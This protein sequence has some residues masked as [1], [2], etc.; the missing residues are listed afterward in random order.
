MRVLVPVVPGAAEGEPVDVGGRVA[1]GPPVHVIDL[2]ERAGDLAAAYGAG[3]VQGFQ[4]LPLRR[5]GEPL[6][7]AEVE[8]G[9]AAAEQQRRHAGV[10][11]DAAGLGGGDR[12]AVGQPCRYLV[13]GDCL[14]VADHGD[15]RR[16]VPAGQHAGQRGRGAFGDVAVVVGAG[17]LGERCDDAV[18]DGG[19]LG[20]QPSLYVSAAVEGPVG[21]EP[22]PAIPA[23]G[24]DGRTVG[25]VA[26]GDHI[27][28]AAPQVGHLPG[29]ESL[30]GPGE[31]ERFG[32][33]GLVVVEPGDRGRDADRVT[34]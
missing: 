16:L 32:G 10:Q 14:E 5:G 31:Q 26:F 9:V 20:V 18:P 8:R 15:A 17:G 29:G 34:V 4:Y 11:G 23:P 33:G 30:V 19:V 1:E 12:R 7:V 2:A 24:V 6:P 25:T 3:R 13:A 28:D 22:R 21:G 27:A